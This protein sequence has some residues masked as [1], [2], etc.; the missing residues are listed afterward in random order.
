MKSFFQKDHNFAV[1]Q[2]QNQVSNYRKN[3]LEM[4]RW[5]LQIEFYLLRE[6]G[7]KITTKTFLWLMMDT[8]FN[9][10]FEIQNPIISLQ[11]EYRRS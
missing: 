9:H 8:F 6:V 2:L 1:S 3:D 5:T 10:R 11:I 4:E 7:R